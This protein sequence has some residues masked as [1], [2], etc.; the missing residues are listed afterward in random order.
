[1]EVDLFKVIGGKKGTSRLFIGGLHGKEG[2]ST[3][4]AFKTIKD[5][6]VNEGKLVLCNLPPSPYLSTL[7][8]LYFLSLAGMKVI[9]IIQKYKPGIYLEL[10][11]Y[12]PDKKQK[13]MNKDRKDIFGV[14]GLVE[15]EEGVLI[16]STSPLIRST[17]FD[18]NDFPFILEIPCNSPVDSLEIPSKIMKIAAQSDNRSQIMKKIRKDYPYQVERLDDYFNEFSQNFWPAFQEVKKNAL[19]MEIKTFL[20]LDKLITGL[21]REEGFDLNPVQMK[22]LGQ[23]LIVYH[24]YNLPNSDLGAN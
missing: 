10:H 15:L 13:L 23:A 4:H 19:E 1:M 17:F 16:G 2:L 18:L 6:D 12:H 8:P 9:D 20:D 7:D 24:E 5:I 3:I 22:Q 14:P 11:C 21:V